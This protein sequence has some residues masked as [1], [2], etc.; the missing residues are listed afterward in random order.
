MKRKGYKRLPP[1]LRYRTN[2]LLLRNTI[3][4]DGY[5]LI[6]S[7][8]RTS[9]ATKSSEIVIDGFPRS[10]CTYAA[11]AFSEANPLIKRVDGHTHSART[12]ARAVQLGIPCILLVR[13]PC[14]AVAS[15]VQ[16][17]SGIRLES[18]LKGYLEFYGALLPI[19]NIVEVAPFDVAVADFGS[20]IRACNERYGSDF[21]VY[22]PD[23]DRESR[24]RRRI[25]DASRLRSGGLVR[26][27]GVA[28]PSE[29]RRS[30]TAVLSNLTQSQEDLLIQA[31]E[32]C[33][34]FA[35]VTCSRLDG[36]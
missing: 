6:R 11:V 4:A 19:R 25:E 8:L 30:A 35:A 26:E 20:V 36:Q 34:A 9:R 33:R 24:V 27:S 3:L 16:L 31:H 32:T 18:A 14:E 13:D 7:S 23:S 15:L 5:M 28:R 12:I 10:A 2:R 21:S 22:T 1:D 17:S 29:S